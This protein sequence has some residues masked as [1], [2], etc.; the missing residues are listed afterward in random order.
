M[1]RNFYPGFD[2]NFLFAL[3][4][5]AIL[6][7]DMVSRPILAFVNTGVW[8]SMS[9]FHVTRSRSSETAAILE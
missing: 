2:V 5:T 8:P 3:W 6:K 1:E 4:N 7:H 9:R